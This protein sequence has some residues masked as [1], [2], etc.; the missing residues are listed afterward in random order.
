MGVGLRNLEMGKAKFQKPTWSGGLKAWR[1]QRGL[2]GSS[3]LGENKGL[4]SQE[5][6]PG[7]W[8]RDSRGG[9]VTHSF[10]NMLTNHRCYISVFIYH[11]EFMT[12]KI[13]E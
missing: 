12:C 4:R 8:D 9:L 6:V 1:L 10:R 5:T 2:L 3:H 11:V 13:S 7:P